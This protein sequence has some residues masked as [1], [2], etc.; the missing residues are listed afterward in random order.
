MNGRVLGDTFGKFTCYTPNGASTVDYVLLSESVL[1]QILYMKVSNFLPTLS[2]CH[3]M[4]EWSLCAKYCT[5][6][7]NSDV[8]THEMS[9]GFI[10]SDDSRE[11]FKKALESD[12][13][14]HD[15]IHF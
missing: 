4:L 14:Q 7:N 15:S 10:W 9:P 8:C 1:D 12:E 13:I 6:P 2:D 5:E 3:C 11:L